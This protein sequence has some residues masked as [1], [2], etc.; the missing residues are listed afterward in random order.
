MVRTSG[1][2]VVML[3]G[4]SLTTALGAA[5]ALGARR[6]RLAAVASASLPAASGLLA[7]YAVLRAGVASAK[8]PKY[9]VQ[10]Q[11]DGMT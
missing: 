6:S 10:S 1:H 4:A 8:D 3:R 2:A 7:K 9:V 11:R 5:V